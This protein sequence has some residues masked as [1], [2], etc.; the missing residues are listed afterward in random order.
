M[1]E[2][3]RKL[4]AAGTA[5]C[6]FFA[7]H[8]AAA[9]SGATVAASEKSF[10]FDKNNNMIVEKPECAFEFNERVK[11]QLTP[12]LKRELESGLDSYDIGDPTV[13]YYRKRAELLFRPK[14]TPGKQG[15]ADA[16]DLEID[17]NVCS[18]EV[19]KV[20]FVTPSPG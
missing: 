1:L 10:T 2:T 5:C 3:G 13:I 7:V 14:V 20:Y 6:V 17:V 15:P 19:E 18:H 12:I 11:E 9:C 4:K 16:S 8:V